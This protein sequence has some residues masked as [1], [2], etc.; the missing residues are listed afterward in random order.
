MKSITKSNDISIKLN[1]D[2]AVATIKTLEGQIQKLNFDINKSANGTITGFTLDK[3][4]PVQSFTDKSSQAEQ[5][6]A[7]QQQNDLYKE[8][9]TLLKQIYQL[10]NAITDAQQK[11]MARTQQQLELMKQQKQSTYNSNLEGLN[12]DNQ[13]KIQQQEAE[14]INNKTVNEAKYQDKIEAENAQIQKQ[15]ELYKEQMKSPFAIKNSANETPR[16]T[17]F[18]W[19]H[20]NNLTFG[21]GKITPTFVDLLPSDVS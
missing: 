7:I 10:D 21:I 19:T 1:D 15:I 14:L 3:T 16:H 20:G 2:Q 9:Q 6:Q 13:V 5:K 4:Q 8:T 12:S 11:G 18:D 17:T